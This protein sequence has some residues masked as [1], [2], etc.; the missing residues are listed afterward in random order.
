[1]KIISIDSISRKNTF[2]HINNYLFIFIHT[3]FHKAQCFWMFCFSNKD[4]RAFPHV[5]LF[6]YFNISV[7]YIILIIL[8]RNLL[9][10]ALWFEKLFLAEFQA[11]NILIPILP[12]MSTFLHWYHQV[13]LPSQACLYER[14]I[15][16]FD[17]Y[18]F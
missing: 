6:S 11:Y 14:D 17:C 12:P 15:F 18:N 10:R 2:T 9:I 4:I 1:M 8:I 13:S 7:L 5:D 3:I 16:K